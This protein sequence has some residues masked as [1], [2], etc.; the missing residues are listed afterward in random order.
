MAEWEP[1]QVGQNWHDVAIPTTET[2][3]QQLEQGCSDVS[4]G[5]EDFLFDWEQISF[6][7]RVHS[8]IYTVL[9]G[10]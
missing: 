9:Q 3:V 1:V 4:E 8:L 6:A 5:E 2:F 7:N 10:C